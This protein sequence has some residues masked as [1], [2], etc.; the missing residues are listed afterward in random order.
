M[1]GAASASGPDFSQGIGL[2]EIPAEGTIAG[3]VGNEPVLLSRLDGEL[4][5]IGATCTHY[6]GSLGEGLA[7]GTSV[8]CP[9]HHACFDLRTGAVL[10]APALDP[11]DR[12]LVEVD[13]DRAFVRSRIEHQH[14]QTPSVGEDLQNV[15]IVGG[16][17]AGLACAHEL[18]T[19]GFG[20]KVTILSADKDPP[21][22]RPNLSKNYLA[23]TAQEDWLWL[24]SADWYA[25]NRID[26]QLATEVA[27]IDPD[28]R[29]VRC[30][31]DVELPFDRLL[32][33]TGAEPN[34]L[35][36]P[37]F[38][39]PGVHTLRSVSDA[40]AIRDLARPDSRVVVVG[41]SFIGLE[42]AAAL[43]QRGVS[44]DVVSV[45]EVPLEHVFGRELGEQIQALHES[46]GVRFHLSSVVAGFDGKAVVLADGHSI[47]ADFVVVGIGVRPRAKLAEAA[48]AKVENGVIVDAFLETSLPGVYAAGDIAAFPDPMT[49]ERVRVEHWVV[50]ERQGQ[51]AAANMMG[52]RRPFDSA[53]FFWTEQYGVAIRYVGRASG[54]DA[55][56]CEG[57]FDAGSLTARYFVEGRHRATATIGRDRDNLEDEL[58]LERG[59]AL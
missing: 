10:R 52:Q 40:K 42:A 2:G 8:R 3:R 17:A 20:G 32:I 25:E 31:S 1:G 30:A 18:R 59:S 9:L 50:A 24:R 49:G 27:R 7:L 44:V 43:R 12:W 13:G 15:V 34:R 47:P 14:A 4:Y 45:E 35:Q 37:G 28:R 38:D 56:T 58:E 5:A 21:C 53:P 33:A 29:V 51:V 23:G 54:W 48:G 6:G 11:V 41:A 57:D 22:D 26:L 19:L 36:V 16:G 55:V 39:R 46:K